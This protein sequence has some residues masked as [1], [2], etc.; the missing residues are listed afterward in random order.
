[1]YTQCIINFCMH[2]IYM[3]VHKTL[4]LKIKCPNSST[5]CNWTGKLKERENH[6]KQ[7]QYEYVD[8][9]CKCSNQEVTKIFEKI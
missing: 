7:C 5:N 9:E 1:M 6:K 4:A 8:C 3:Q 2:D